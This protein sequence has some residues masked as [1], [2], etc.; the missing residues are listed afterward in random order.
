[1][2][3]RQ[4]VP[5]KSQQKAIN[6]LR[7]AGFALVVW[8]PHELQNTDPGTMEDRS[9]EFGWDIIQNDGGEFIEP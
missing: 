5:S 8:Y 6:E 7:E 4:I 2:M 1:M 9:I 3:A